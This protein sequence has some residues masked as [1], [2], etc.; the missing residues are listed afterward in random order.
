[1]RTDRGPGRR[2]GGTTFVETLLAVV[3]ICM[4][5]LAVAGGTWAWA[6][7]QRKIELHERALATG[8][9][10]LELLTSLPPER[11]PAPGE[12]SLASVAGD[13]DLVRVLE[14]REV[15]GHELHFELVVEEHPVAYPDYFFG[16]S[17]PIPYLDFRRFRMRVHGGTLDL[18]LVALK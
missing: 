9:A 3:L 11:R 1:M 17:E 15:A 7:T 10:R 14:A 13:P 16:G 12:Y 4:V 18:E 5:M 6:R 2:R 8:V